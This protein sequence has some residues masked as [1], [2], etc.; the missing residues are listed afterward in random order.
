MLLYATCPFCS[1]SLK[2]QQQQLDTRDGL[3]RCGHCKKV[4]NAN[5]HLIN[6]AKPE[7]QIS[8]TVPLLKASWEKAVTSPKKR[9]HYGIL[10][11]LLLIIFPLQF[12]YFDYQQILNN[13]SIRPAIDRISSRFDLAIP[14]YQDLKQIKII[15]RR[16]SSHPHVKNALQLSIIIKNTAELQQAYPLVNFS[17][18]SLNGDTIVQYTI[19]PNQYLPNKM[20]GKAFP[21][22]ASQLI[23]LNFIEPA[24]DTIGF[25]INFIEHPLQ[26]HF[27]FHT[28][29]KRLLVIIEN[30]QITDY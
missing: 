2:I 4:F 15:H 23:E 6:P 13:A 8:E 19:P 30:L 27:P 20:I 11:L 28:L 25:E 12:L 9:F 3:V 29:L 21:K 17:L 10:C 18:T 22:N 26:A 1:S 16:V 14:Y 7:Q 5:D 24:L